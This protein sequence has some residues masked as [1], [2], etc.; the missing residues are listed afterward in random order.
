M[1]TFHL[2][3]IL[4][5]P[6]FLSQFLDQAMS[7]LI[8]LILISHPFNLYTQNTY[9]REFLSV[10]G[11]EKIKSYL[12]DKSLNKGLGNMIK[13]RPISVYSKLS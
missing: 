12:R 6:C 10:V 8:S 5:L 13:S 3:L 11:W 9:I 4:P 2:T 7:T 1:Q